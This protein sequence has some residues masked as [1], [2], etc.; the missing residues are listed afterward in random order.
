MYSQVIETRLKGAQSA[1]NPHH[2]AVVNPYHSAQQIHLQTTKPDAP[3]YHL[4]VDVFRR[5]G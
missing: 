4:S 5:F 3:A 2:E 1:R